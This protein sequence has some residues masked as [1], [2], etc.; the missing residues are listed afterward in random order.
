MATKITNEQIEKYISGELKGAELENFIQ[1]IKNDSELEYEVQLHQQVKEV[2]SDTE[3]IKF[4]DSLNKIHDDYLANR[5]EP[6]TAV[7]MKIS[8]FNKPLMK[9][10]AGFTLILGISSI[11]WLILRPSFNE[12]LY[13]AYYKPYDASTIVRSGNSENTDNFS[14]AMQMYADGNYSNAYDLLKVVS[15]SDSNYMPALFFAGISAMELNQFENA[16][17]SFS[18]IIKANTSLYVEN[19]EWYLALCYLKSKNKIQAKAT[20]AK[21]V[22]R[23]GYYKP[24]AEKLIHELND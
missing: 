1:I 23:N 10:A 20:L 22:A 24:D 21:I 13:S 18:I 6:N 8:W 12:R 3:G 19:A 5:K 2:L 15:C 14:K 16:E 11:L 9:I 17:T 4:R 7:I